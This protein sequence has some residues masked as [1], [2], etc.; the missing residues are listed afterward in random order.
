MATPQM[1]PVTADDIL[2]LARQ[3]AVARAARQI[4]REHCAIT[5][6][7]DAVNALP[8][9]ALPPLPVEPAAEVERVLACGVR[10][11]LANDDGHLVVSLREDDEG[12]VAALTPVESE[13][14]RGDV[15]RVLAAGKV[16]K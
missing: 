9:W 11:R 6:L 16:G 1:K 7:I 3:V 13:Q 10:L 2:A 14:M 12:V 4:N 8:S 5:M 15:A